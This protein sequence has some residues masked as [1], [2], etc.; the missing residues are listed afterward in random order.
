MQVRAR[1]QNVSLRPFISYAREDQAAAVRLYGDLK[2]AGIEPWLDLAELLPGHEWKP[3]IRRAMRAASH[4]IVLLSLNSV[5]KTGFVQNETREALELAES[6]PPGQ[7]FLIPARI[8]A[9]TPKYERLQDLHW[10]DLF[11]DYHAG[12]SKIVAALGVSTRSA[13][14]V[15]KLEV[16]D[17]D[18]PASGTALTD[19]TLRDFL[20]SNRLSIHMDHKIAG[21]TLSRAVSELSAV[22]LNSQVN[23]LHVAGIETIE[24]LERTLRKHKSQ[25]AGW[26][27]EWLGGQSGPIG[28][29]IYITY[30]GYILLCQ[31]GDVTRLI[32]FLEAAHIDSATGREAIAKK[33]MRAY[34]EFAREGTA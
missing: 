20:A 24:Q 11:P 23:A 26:A 32:R 12:L 30:L 2:A 9:T 21:F 19:S 28:Q 8:D 34:A 6:Q 29:G 10:V 1:I 14:G 17:N 5:D 13:A 15:P 27:E 31:R 7:I 22:A 25:I 18:E 33:V 16:T 4:I 3:A